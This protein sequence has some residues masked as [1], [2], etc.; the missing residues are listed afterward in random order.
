MGGSSYAGNDRPVE[1]R[2]GRRRGKREPDPAKPVHIM[3]KWGVGY[4]FKG[5][6]QPTV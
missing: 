1:D 5:E 4:Y 6:S 2:M 3:T